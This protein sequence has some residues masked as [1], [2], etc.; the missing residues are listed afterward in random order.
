MVITL[1]IDSA[2]LTS[3]LNRLP[4]SVDINMG[5]A[6]FELADTSAKSIRK[7]LLI[8]QKLASRARM[9]QRIEAR[10]VNKHR[11]VVFMPIRAHYLD[12]MTPHWVALKRGRRITSWTKKYYGKMVKEGRSRVFKGPRGGILFNEQR[13]SY[14]WVTPDPFVNA[15]FQRAR[16]QFETILK[17]SITKAIK[18]AKS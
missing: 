18:E 10:K 6:A 9:A 16:R 3:F 8:Q 2:A 17:R 4:E 1:T 12:T 14:L 7:Q 11:S 5:D 13:R 15:G